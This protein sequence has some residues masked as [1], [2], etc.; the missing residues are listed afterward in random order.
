MNS[1]DIFDAEGNNV[2]SEP[3]EEFITVKEEIEEE[4]DEI[5]DEVPREIGQ[6]V[7]VKVSNDVLLR[8]KV[9]FYSG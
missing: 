1:I 6:E 3:Q 2:K 9:S 8:T 4:V 5:E 7:V